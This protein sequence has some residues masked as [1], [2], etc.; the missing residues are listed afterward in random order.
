MVQKG[1]WR[2]GHFGKMSSEQ[3]LDS[4]EMIQDFGN[5]WQYL[6]FEIK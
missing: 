5:T 4:K 1:G 6:T 2:K 3:V